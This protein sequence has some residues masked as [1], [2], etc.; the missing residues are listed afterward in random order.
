[1]VD[2]AEHHRKAVVD[3]LNIA[4]ANFRGL[5]TSAAAGGVVKYC[6][7]II[8]EHVNGNTFSDAALRTVAIGLSA[9]H[10]KLL[11]SR[12]KKRRYPG[13]PRRQT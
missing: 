11:E 10:P 12:F 6:E 8:N 3:A 2:Q 5:G 4:I 13:R 9:I 7:K 1:M